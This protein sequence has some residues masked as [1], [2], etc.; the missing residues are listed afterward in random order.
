MIEYLG[1]IILTWFL[2]GYSITLSISD[3]G[4][5]I[6][7]VFCQMF[8]LL[9]SSDLPSELR[10]YLPL[11]LETMLE[12][13]VQRGDELVPYETVV[14][15]LEADTLSVSTSI[16]LEAVSRFSCGPFGQTA[17]LALQVG[18]SCSICWDCSNVISKQTLQK[19]KYKIRKYN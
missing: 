1:K 12:S 14:S 2:V 18:F 4:V 6:E 5:K 19:F 9:D 7:V 11:L 16:G 3:F 13:P 15:E 8:V 17:M 10:P